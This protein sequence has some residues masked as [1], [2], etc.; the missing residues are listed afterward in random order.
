[1]IYY[2]YYPVCGHLKG[3][4]FQTSMI[5]WEKSG[6]KTSIALINSP[7]YMFIVCMVGLCL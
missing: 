2:S 4:L 1:M 3:M 7:D 5:V 6:I